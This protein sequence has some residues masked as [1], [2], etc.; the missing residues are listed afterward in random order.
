MGVRS[1]RERRIRLGSREKHASTVLAR[2]L[3]WQQLI[4][5]PK[6]T[7]QGGRPMTTTGF[8][9]MITIAHAFLL[10]AAGLVACSSNSSGLRV[11]GST[12][13]GMIDGTRS[14]DGAGIDRATGQGG[15]AGTGGDRDA[16][17]EAGLGAGGRI[18]LDGGLAGVGGAAGGTS[19]P[20]SGGI[21]RGGSG[22]RARGTGGAGGGR[23]GGAVGTGGSTRRDG[24]ADS[25]QDAA[26]TSDAALDTASDLP[27]RVDAID[28]GEG[29]GN[30]DEPCCTSRA[31]NLPSLVC[32]SGGAGG[33]GICVA[34]GG[35]GDPCC[36]GNVCTA[37]NTSCT[38]G[39]RG[40]CR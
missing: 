35:A 14:I 11:D 29:C 24:S 25:G 15:A 38:G 5:N 16:S 28:G 32:E 10:V 4:H 7:D 20:G 12:D 13:G 21:G 2:Q 3:L 8:F 27:S 33:G 1:G 34:C 37:P 40:T 30:L 6:P 26:V 17:G 9:R 19:L 36:E 23:T 18:R 39:G 31:C 22:G